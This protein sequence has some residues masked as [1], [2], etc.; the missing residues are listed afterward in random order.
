MQMELIILVTTT[1][2]GLD[3]LS[4]V[5]AVDFNVY[6]SNREFSLIRLL[7]VF[8]VGRQKSN[9]VEKKLFQLRITNKINLFR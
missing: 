1:F 6:E 7:H 8:F 3:C 9:D 4:H 5:N 2:N